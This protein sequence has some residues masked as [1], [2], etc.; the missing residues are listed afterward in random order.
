MLQS[1]SALVLA[2]M[3][4]SPGCP[5]FW[6]VRSSLPLSIFGKHD[7]GAAEAARQRRF[8]LRRRDPEF[9]EVFSDLRVCVVPAIGEVGAG[10]VGCAVGVAPVDS[11]LRRSRRVLGLDAEFDEIVRGSHRRRLS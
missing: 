6:F 2:T 1:G 9:L 8:I 11:G 7:E 4:G 5:A 10:D 3:S